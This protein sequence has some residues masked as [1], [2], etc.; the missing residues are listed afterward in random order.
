MV[1]GHKLWMMQVNLILHS[2]VIE[3]SFCLSKGNECE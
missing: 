1:V 2:S 3:Q